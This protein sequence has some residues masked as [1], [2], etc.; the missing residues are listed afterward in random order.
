MRTRGERLSLYYQDDF[1][2]LYHGDCIELSGEWAGADVLVT[3]PPY[4]MAY[5]GFGGRKGRTDASRNSVIA[6]DGSTEIRDRALSA[7]GETRPA[8]VFGRW[9]I[10]RPAATK[11]R[12]IWDKRPCG[13]MGDTKMPW[14]S[15]EEEIYVLGSGFVGK[16][17]ANIVRCQTIHSQDVD[18]PNHPTPKP[19]GLME[20]L[21]A[22]CPPG[23]LA[24][25]FA[26]SGAT[27]VA[28][29][30]LG[31]KAIGVELEERYC[32]VIAKRLSQDLL[33]LEWTA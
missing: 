20:M 6:G 25:P 5:K 4:G 17:E 1:V 14:G 27:L 13:F 16:R 11:E 24:D 30:N 9:N 23:R 15:A 7:W 33:E 10:Q 19:V 22:K 2:T 12:L 31:R 29:K 8:L 18:R 28:A 26:G 32:E 21:I 3:D